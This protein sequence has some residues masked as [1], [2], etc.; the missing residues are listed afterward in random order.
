MPQSISTKRRP[1][2]TFY[3]D[4]NLGRTFKSL[5]Q[6]SGLRAQFALDLFEP[7]TADTV[8]LPYIANN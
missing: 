8:W 4:E 7:G 6:A 3:I 2:P 1:E 5:L